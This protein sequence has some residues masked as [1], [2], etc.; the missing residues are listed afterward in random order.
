VHFRAS[1]DSIVTYSSPTLK[2]ALARG[3]NNN[4]DVLRLAAALAVIVS[5]AWPLTLG[6]GTPEPLEHLTGSSLGRHAVMLFFFLSGMLVAESADRNRRTPMRFV[7]AR[8]ARLFPGLAV[9]LVVGLG[10]AV[11][12]GG[13]T[14]GAAEA[15]TY[16][17]RGLSLFFLEHTVTGAWLDQPYPSAMN[18]S[19]WTLS[20]EVASY[21]VVAV[22][23]WS[24]A[25]NRRLGSVMAI[26]GV[27]LATQAL[28]ALL[29]AGGGLGYHVN[30]FAPLILTFLTGVAAWRF[31]AELPLSP[32]IAVLLL[33]AA[34]ALSGTFLAEA[35]GSAALGMAA[36]VLAFRTPVVRLPGDL[37][38][39]VYVYGWPVS[40]AVMATIAPTSPWANALLS[41]LA[42]LPLAAA[43]WVLIEKPSLRLNRGL[44]AERPP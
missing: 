28:A 30:Q 27:V 20:H 24:G 37:S 43:S 16:V 34:V 9:A 21:G 15:V 1:R 42:V 11:A 23:V 13:A 4:L 5:H 6:P 14:P 31:R 33:G 25:L 29:P 8:V 10:I 19:L 38:Y 39:G 3:R 18:G 12:F 41:C 22:L 35:S 7:R 2:S 17:L 36:L 40:Q 44:G 26:L 32:L